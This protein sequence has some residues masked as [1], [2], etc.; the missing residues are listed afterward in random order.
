MKQSEENKKKRSMHDQ[1]YKKYYFKIT[2]FCT[3][4]NLLV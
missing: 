1:I 2:I 4:Q 3:K